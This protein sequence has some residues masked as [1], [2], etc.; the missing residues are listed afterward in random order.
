MGP[1]HHSK[2]VQV[3]KRNRSKSRFEDSYSLAQARQINNW[4]DKQARKELDELLAKNVDL[5]E[6]RSRETFR[7]EFW[8][9]ADPALKGALP[10][11]LAHTKRIMETEPSGTKKRFQH[12]FLKTCRLAKRMGISAALKRTS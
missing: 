12:E 10:S 1:L 8:E 4:S 11:I 2:V 5:V 6:E 7:R 3:P 9:M